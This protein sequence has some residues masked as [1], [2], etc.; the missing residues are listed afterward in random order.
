MT[1]AY[2]LTGWATMAELIK[3]NIRVTN[4]FFMK[5]GLLK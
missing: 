2:F 5:S 1:R 4:R 3:K